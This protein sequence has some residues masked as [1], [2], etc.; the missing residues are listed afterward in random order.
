MCSRRAAFTL[1]EVLIS[2]ALLGLILPALYQSV[3]LLRDSNY[4]LLEHLQKSKESTLATN[5]LYL[6]IASSDGNLSLQDGEFDRLCIERTG[7]SLYGLSVAKVCWVVLRH[8]HT[9][10]RVEGNN[11]HLP[12]GLNERVEV[13]QIMSHVLLFDVYRKKGM[14]LVLLQEENKEPIAFMVD[15]VTKPKPKKKKLK[16]KK[17]KEHKAV[18][19][20]DTNSTYSVPRDQ[21]SSLYRK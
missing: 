20:K 10:V 11:Y 5:T 17:K 7:N 4:Q 6:D 15:A 12:T 3:D 21:N 2:I 18:S 14:V 8:Q 1:V 13:D 16:K 19:R 9:L